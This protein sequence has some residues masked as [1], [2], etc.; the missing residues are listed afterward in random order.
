MH[1]HTNAFT[2]TQT[3][4]RSTQWVQPLTCSGA[5]R[6]RRCSVKTTIRARERPPR[7][8]LC[9]RSCSNKHTHAELP[10]NIPHVGER[11]RSQQ[12][13]ACIISLPDGLCSSAARTHS[14]SSTLALRLLVYFAHRM[15]LCDRVCLVL[16]CRLRTAAH[17]KL[18]RRRPPL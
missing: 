18:G 17:T 7:T 13:A 1:T 6:V 14:F 3:H 11:L 4:T 2:H 16:V 5:F 9:T 10:R 15:G 12:L 8:Q